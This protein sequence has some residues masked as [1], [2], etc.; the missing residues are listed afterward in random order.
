[1]WGAFG[2]S[3][4]SCVGHA[5]YLGIKDTHSDTKCQQYL[6]GCSDLF[7]SKNIWSDCCYVLSFS[8]V[9]QWRYLFNFNPKTQSSQGEMMKQWTL[10]NKY[11]CL[12]LT[13]QLLVSLSYMVCKEDCYYFLLL[14]LFVLGCGEGLVFSVF[15][16]FFC[17]WVSCG[18]SS[19]SYC[20]RIL[21]TH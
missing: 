3:S 14:Y 15:H 12:P 5:A 17:G 16:L 9:C 4:V 1:M 6:Q 21:F 11:R 8:I 2:V 20:T 18:E 10:E 13:C 19:F 7:I